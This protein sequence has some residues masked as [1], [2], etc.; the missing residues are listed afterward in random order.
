MKILL[1]SNSTMPGFPYLEWPKDL[2][3]R[4]LGE[5][6][7]VCFIPYAA[8]NF[9]YDQY[10]QKV[11]EALNPLGIKVNSIHHSKE[12]A[13]DIVSAKAIMVG[14]GNTFHLLHE[15]YRLKLMDAIRTKVNDG[16][17]YIGWSAGS[18]VACPTIK[19]TNDMPI[20][21]PPKFEALNLVN[22]QI[23]PHFTERTIDGHGGE[24]RLDRLMEYSAINKIPVVC[25][26]EGCALKIDQGKIKLLSAEPVKMVSEHGVIS[27]LHHGVID[28]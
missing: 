20:I 11:Q 2:I 17:P 27:S 15:L 12:P 9:S 10:E 24:S 21:E 16:A 5:L 7:E 3:D 23:N 4:I 13:Q 19:T 25:L 22:F 26:P 6:R 1:L 28:I 14:G 8:V 18:N